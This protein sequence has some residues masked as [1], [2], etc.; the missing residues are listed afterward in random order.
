MADLGNPAGTK[1]EEPSQPNSTISFQTDPNKASQTGKPVPKPA[2]SNSF[3]NLNQS[4]EKNQTGSLSFF[5]NG[6]KNPIASLVSS[7]NKTPNFQFKL[8]ENQNTGNQMQTNSTQKETKPTTQ[9]PPKTGENVPQENKPNTSQNTISQMGNPNF[10]NFQ[11]NPSLAQTTTAKPTIQSINYEKFLNKRVL[12]VQNGWREA[13][14]NVQRNIKKVGLTINRNEE[15]LRA[16]LKTLDHLSES[17]ENMVG[18]FRLF[19]ESLDKII[20]QQKSLEIQFDFMENELDRLL[21]SQNVPNSKE[22]DSEDLYSKSHVLCDKLASFDR[23]SSNF[24]REINNH[25]SKNNLDIEFNSSFNNFFE[26]LSVLETQINQIES[27]LSKSV[28]MGN[29]N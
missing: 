2:N 7:E 1:N 23:L 3:F 15:D 25:T 26:S 21:D 8:G 11:A 27:K 28:G 17:K 6:K 29:F 22:G 18:E 5:T 14:R 4:N 19:D 20:S 16:S 10:F 24:G 9:I 13:T 12:E